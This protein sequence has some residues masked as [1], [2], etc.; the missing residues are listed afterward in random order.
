MA[1]VNISYFK[2][3]VKKQKQ[4]F[5]GLAYGAA[6]SKFQGAHTELKDSFE[7]HPVTKELERGEDAGEGVLDY[8]NLYSF[9]GFDNGTEP[10]VPLRKMLRGVSLSSTATTQEV[11]DRLIFSFPV[12]GLPTKE[13]LDNE[14]KMPDWDSG[15]SWIDA[16][17]RGI[18]GLSH[19]FFKR[20]SSFKQRRSGPA[21][22]V[23][24]IIRSGTFSGIS[25]LSDLIANF[26]ERI[27]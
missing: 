26:K 25:Y 22:Q 27:R 16:V 5:K 11:G 3:E 14:A 8:G 10:I 21:Y 1:V 24:N 23:K 19:Y 13:E 9:I 12:T 15:R 6:L 17:E 20:F 4:A 18:E 2:T 7:K